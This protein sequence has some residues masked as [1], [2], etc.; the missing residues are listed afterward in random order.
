MRWLPGVTPP[1]EPPDPQV[2]LC[3]DDTGGVFPYSVDGDELLAWQ[4]SLGSECA[5]QRVAEALVLPN[6]VVALSREGQ[7]FAVPDVQ[8][9][10]VLRLADV[11]PLE[12]FPHAVAGALSLS[13][14]GVGLDSS[15]ARAS[16]A[17]WWR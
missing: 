10:R 3:V 9:P 8:Q 4:L 15:S 11:P 16:C 2:L 14:V 5:A 1:A 12:A 13:T 6:S 17:T 7:L